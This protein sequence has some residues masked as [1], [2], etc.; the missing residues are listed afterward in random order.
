MRS[1]LAR[2]IA[3][4][5]LML[6]S[7][8][9]TAAQLAWNELPPLPNADGV[10]GPFV[11]VHGDALIVAGGANFPKPVWESG[12]AFHDAIHVLVKEGRGAK[13]A[14][15]WVSGGKLERPI[16]YGASV[17]TSRG[18]VCMGGNDA[19]RTYADAF[20]L[21]WNPESETVEQQQLPSLPGPCT[22]AAATVI[23]EK[24]YLA[25]GAA[26][27][28]L[29]SAR[30]TFWMLDLSQTESG[31]LVWE[32]LP[33][34][35]GPSRAFAIAAA[36]NNGVSDCIYLISGRRM[37]EAGATEFLT[38]VY[39]FT[40][41]AYRP[42]AFD[43][44][45]GAYSG[46]VNPW[47]RRADVPR[48]VMAGTGI[49]LGQSHVLVLAGADE[50][51]FFDVDALKDAHPGFPKEALAYHTI[52]NTWTSAGPIPANQV[53][54]TAVRWG[55][56]S[57]NDP[58][59]V[60]S[61][62]IRPRV[63]T[64]QVWEVLPIKG[65][66]RFGFADFSVLGLYLAGMIAMGVYFSFRNKNA[67]DFFRGGRRIPW[68]VAGLSIFATMLS[69]I[70]FMAIPAKTYATDWVFFLVNMMAVV[71]AP[72]V[73]MLF[74][75]FFRKVD[76]VSAYQY[77]EKRF[78]RFARQ[79]ASASFVLFQLGRTAVV[80]YLPALALRAITPLSEQQSILL[81]GILSIVYCALG[82][83]E[84][85]AWTD[86]VQSL[87]LL[88]GAL[89]SLILI[90]SQVDGG[91]AG[92][93]STAAE[94]GKFHLANLDFS[95]GSFATAALWVVV[96]GGFS[97]NLVP[98]TSDMS[99]VQRY[100]AVQDTGRARKAIWTNAIACIPASLLFFGIGT[101]LYVFYANHP[102][103]LD[104]TF[105]NDAIFPLFIA[106]EL[107]LG[108][109]GLVVAGLFA[110]AQST[111]ATSINSM[112]TAVVEDFMRP[113]RI[114]KTERGYLRMGRFFTVVLGTGGVALALLFA[115][116]DI[117][118]LWDQFMTILGL[119]GGSMCGLFCLGIFT[120]RANGPGAIIGTLAGAGGLFLVQRYT[121]THFLLYA[122]VGIVVCFV[123]GYLA[124]LAFS[125]MRKP[126]GG[127]TV[128]TLAGALDPASD[129][130]PTE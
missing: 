85:V 99:I 79:F 105:K 43:S 60:A 118:S 100:M 72:L 42:E 117:K 3:W 21:R 88:G 78:N 120:T 53:T 112:S 2:R 12:K 58:V 35:P 97:Q 81:M 11:G 22:N 73:I 84:A 24:V 122:F 5:A 115:S 109:P 6:L 101:A 13:T 38:D 23:G 111:I 33:S 63:R 95:S 37:N 39:E 40:P 92:F 108:V 86:A 83:L 123:V 17:S 94:N 71:V 68:F 47:R 48:C 102:D 80:L 28:G 126:I 31:N 113:W 103:R 76:A 44:N 119:F 91:V 26:G 46:E 62:E 106:R 67:D 96:L 55:N 32:L 45:T 69:S 66:T 4:L 64:P 50:K 52:T 30:S 107:P 129:R 75:P 9:A 125:P 93:F 65:E 7:G 49:A 41:A 16:A 74:L 14:Y 110:A 19:E 29:E 70:T 77:L 87:V 27:L 61:G 10:A 36:Q 127:L 51:H 54:T 98:Y 59:I 25:G 130:S 121:Q 128:Y 56:D 89:F 15:R 104:P 8:A 57:V 34:W 116:A 20:L 82:G 90:M 1:I 114:I 18:V 124:S